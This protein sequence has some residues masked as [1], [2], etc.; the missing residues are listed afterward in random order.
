MLIFKINGAVGDRHKP[1]IEFAIQ[2]SAVV[3][4]ELDG[5]RKI[6]PD[7]A[8]E[9]QPGRGDLAHV[10]RHGFLPFGKIDLYAVEQVSG[11]AKCLFRQPSHWAEGKPVVGLPTVDIVKADGIAINQLMMGNLGKLRQAGRAGGH[12]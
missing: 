6:F 12:A 9:K 4:A 1:L 2:P 8:G 10:C 3:D 11:E 7:A 5:A